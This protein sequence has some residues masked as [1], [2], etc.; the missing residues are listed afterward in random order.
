[1]KRGPKP[2]HPAKKDA[3]VALIMHLMGIR[4][5]LQHRHVQVNEIDRLMDTVKR[6]PG[7]HGQSYRLTCKYPYK[8]GIV[9]RD[10]WLA[11]YSYWELKHRDDSPL[12]KQRLD[13]LAFYAKRGWDCCTI[14]GGEP[15]GYGLFQPIG[16]GED[17]DS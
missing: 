6:V 17:D 8:V 13:R 14:V 11:I 9:F 7:V 3:R 12:L 1:M 4:R 5:R 10:I 2:E 16:E 15:G